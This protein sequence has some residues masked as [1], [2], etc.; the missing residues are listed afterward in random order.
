MA[1]NSARPV[2]LA[3]AMT[4]LRFS[5]LNSAWRDRSG[6]SGADGQVRGISIWIEI[7]LAIK[8]DRPLTINERQYFWNTTRGHAEF[9]SGARLRDLRFTSRTSMNG[10][11]L[12]VA[13]LPLGHLRAFSTI[14]CVRLDASLRSASER[15]AAFLQNNS[16]ISQKS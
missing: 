10:E 15:T 14:R 3:G 1:A 6:G 11:S 16:G 5:G 2:E 8:R 4:F 7:V 9:A 13:G 12:H